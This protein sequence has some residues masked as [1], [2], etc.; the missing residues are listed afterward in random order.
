[1]I[2]FPL[3]A[4]TIMIDNFK[5]DIFSKNSNGLQKIE[6]S[7]VF[8]LNESVPKYKLKDGIN[9]V[10]SSFYLEDLFTSKSKED[11][12]QLL[13][14]YLNKKHSI[15]VNSIYI[16]KMQ[17]KQT[18]SLDELAKKIEELKQKKDR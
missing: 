2:A 9:I 16:D 1:M 6:V 13:K 10:I 8:D 12:K 3:F 7:L 4:E 17:K 5:T 15:V 14:S 18:I 11:F